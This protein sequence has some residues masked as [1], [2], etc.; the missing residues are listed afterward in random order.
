VRPRERLAFTANAG[1]SVLED[2]QIDRTAAALGDLRMRL[3]G[4]PE[5][6]DRRVGTL[7]SLPKPAPVP[8][9]GAKL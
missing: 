9:N 7:S 1:A 3:S 4:R 2:Y 5:R 8:G 6:G